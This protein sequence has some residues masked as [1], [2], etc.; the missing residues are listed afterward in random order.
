[1]LFK[2]LSV[3]T[4]L[5]CLSVKEQRQK[6]HTISSSVSIFITIVLRQEQKGSH[7]GAQATHDRA[8]E[9]NKERKLMLF[10][11]FTECSASRSASYFDLSR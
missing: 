9:L 7:L 10:F 3:Y 8:S 6:L 11:L 2:H 4:S 5:S 1:M